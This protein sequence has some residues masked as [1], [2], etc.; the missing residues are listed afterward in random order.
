MAKRNDWTEDQITLVLYEYCR[1]PFG[2]FSG[3]KP[4]VIE[5]AQLLGRTPGAIVRKVGNIASFDPNMVAR[6]VYGLSHVAK[7]DKVVWDKYF[8]NW[9]MLAY[10]AEKIL[11]K[12]KGKNLEE[13]IDINLENLPEG[14]DRIQEVKVRINQKFFHETIM[15]SYNN[16]CCITGLNNPDL[17]HACHISDWKND[18][19]NRTNPQNGLCMNVLFHKAYDENLLGISPDYKIHVSEDI[20]GLKKEN[21]DQ[22]F[23]S[24]IMGYHGREI[25]LPRRFLP[26]QELLAKHYEKYQDRVG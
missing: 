26:D 25:K 9:D 2:Q 20:L 16:T 14:V 12:L 4:F 24:L 3:V 7:L 11:A 13:S 19:K 5:L 1:R 23:I 15:S 22:D 18:K 10:N 17:L 6:G 21:V 8:N